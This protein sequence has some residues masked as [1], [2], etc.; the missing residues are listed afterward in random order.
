MD[1]T[2]ASLGTS[3][4]A[5]LAPPQGDPGPARRGPMWRHL[6]P[7]L[8]AFVAVAGVAAVLGRY[9]V[10]LPDMAVFA[11]YLTLAVA[12]PGVLLVRVC[13][14]G[15]LTLVEELALGLVLG[16][17]LEVLAYIAARA[18]GVPLLVVVWPIA[19]Y[20][21]FLAVPRLR[22][23]WRTPPRRDVPAWWSWALALTV[24]YLAAWSAFTFF[25]SNPLTWPDMG[26]AHFEMPYHLALV[27]ELKHHMPPT[28]PLVAGEPL[29]YHW[30][31]YAHF[32]ASSWITGLEPVVLLFRLGPVPM[33]VAF[34]VLVGVI[35]RRVTGSYVGALLSI[36]GSVFVA[37][38]SLHPNANGLLLW[39]GVQ[40]T[41]F[42]GPTQTFGAVL[43]AP[44]VLLLLDLFEQGRL[45]RGRWLLM[46]VF[47]VG[48]MGAKATYLP[49]LI[50][51]LLAAAAVTLV[52]RRRISWPVPAVLGMAAA[53]F[54]YAQVVLFGGAKQGMAVEP[55]ALMSRTWADLTPGDGP[56]TR[57]ALAGITLVFLACWLVT[58]A[59]AFGLLSRPRVLL[60][61]AV[62]LLLGMSA[63]GFGGILLL[64]HPHLGQGYFLQAVYPYLAV[65]AA[66][67]LVVVTRRERTPRWALGCAVAGGLLVAYLIRVLCGVEL[68]LAPGRPE[69][70]LYLPYVALLGVA[71]V[72]AAAALLARRVARAW[73]CV[74][75]LVASAGMPS[76][77]QARAQLLVSRVPGGEAQEVSH[78]SPDQVPQGTLAAGRW[79]R[80]HSLPDD[81]VATNAHCRWEYPDVCDSRHFWLSALSERR[82]LVEGW[83]YTAR[84]HDQAGPGLL[85]EHVPFWDGELF[86]LNEQVFTKPT[87]EALRLLRDGYG[88]RWLIAE[89]PIPEAAARLGALATARFR[90]GDYAIYELRPR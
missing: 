74:I 34:A 78:P 60:Q 43:F 69:S 20:A 9:G 90:A 5:T 40:H 62:A 30:F 13:Y 31:V 52:A 85:P 12:L 27:G 39:T 28:V 42:T 1:M 65:L 15:A 53:C 87:A 58:W 36:A 45:G 33:L 16:Y 54:C 59:G 2:P 14:R 29:L 41:P 67:G 19:T 86:R 70:A 44:V 38:P 50:A 8:P 66:Y 18:A 46:A 51:G 48:V 79:L 61:P 76:A 6:S 80:D 57:G 25:R 55:L 23:H 73:A 71:G 17:V 77:W 10:A 37:I 26:T 84:N 7:W 21:L 11:G 64:G 3:A 68:P 24:V 72:A 49:L 47:L 4:V 81:L 83:A 63:A 88:V 22:R 35:G 75:V 89:R 82:M 56:A 32:A